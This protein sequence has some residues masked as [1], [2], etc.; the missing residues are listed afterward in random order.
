MSKTPKILAFSG[1]LRKDSFNQKLVHV[2]AEGARK[3]GAEVTVISLRD[4]DLPLMNEDLEAEHGLPADA[5]RLKQLMWDH[6]GFLISSP[7]YNSSI[8]PPLKN[9]IDWAS[10]PASQD[11][12]RLSC[13][14]GKYA[15]LVSASPGNLGGLRG[16]VHLRS[17]LSN[18]FVHVIPDQRAISEAHN[19][20]DNQGHLQDAKQQQAVEEIGAKLAEV[21]GKV[22][23]E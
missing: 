21:L 23:A 8:T 1:S 19:A 17:I 13:Y 3:A 14:V 22:L 9:A 6:D 10:R 20:F 2:A 16:L 5:R 7:E 15:G 12:P 4:F 18:I 11:E